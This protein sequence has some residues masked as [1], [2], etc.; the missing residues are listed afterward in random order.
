MEHYQVTGTPEG[1]VSKQAPFTPV[2]RSDIGCPREDTLPLKPCE[3]CIH[4]S[5]VKSI[6]QHK[7]FGYKFIHSS[8][9]WH[10]LCS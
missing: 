1:S 5:K 2:S 3:L 4:G 10:E 7:L 6:V 8:W 9:Y